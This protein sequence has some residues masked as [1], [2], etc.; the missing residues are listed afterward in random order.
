MNALERLRERIS[1][2]FA[3]ALE[4]SIKES[5]EEARAISGCDM[6][7]QVYA[8]L[9]DS[10]DELL[11]NA[12]LLDFFLDDGVL[13]MVIASEGKLY[14]AKLD[15]DSATDTVILGEW[16][17]IKV[18]HVPIETRLTVERQAD[19]R[20]RFVA[21]ANTAILNRVGEIDSMA[22]FD[23]FIQR[24]EDS[25]KY[26]Y[27]TFY[28]I[29][30]EKLLP[31]FRMGQCDYLARDEVAYIVTGLLDESTP[32]GADMARALEENAEIWGTS[33]GF[34]PT[35]PPE[36]AEIGGVR[37]PVYREGEHSELSLIL[38]EDAAAL[39]TA[40]IREEVSM[41]SRIAKALEAL[42][43]SEERIA[44]L[45]TLVDDVK[46]RV[47][48]E[49]MV[50]REIEEAP[51]ETPEVVLVE[52][53]VEEPVEEPAEVVL[54]EEALPA[55]AEGLLSSEPFQG[56]LVPIVESLEA[57]GKRL[58]EAVATLTAT[59][60]EALEPIRTRLD[61]LERTDDE[62]KDEWMKDLPAKRQLTVKYRAPGREQG[63]PAPKTYAETAEET[64]AAIKGGA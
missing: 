52:E 62:K 61:Q 48:D 57:L 59:Q 45:G 18:D 5:N 42:G 27:V 38:K 53:L 19:G 23:N 9:W 26:P 3:E 21:I 6:I 56:I 49:D 8:Q 50:T 64:V 55:L 1:A 43:L 39:F 35:A 15:V 34:N 7:A 10:T 36:L 22:L 2:A 58:E 16:Q 60:T 28:H 13:Y 17:Q 12:W 54:D 25:G 14:R 63:E 32:L 30:N 29:S 20:C 44:E 37:I 40:V 24:A 31:T 51:A 41:D 47:K 33:I 46:H 11:R 4:P